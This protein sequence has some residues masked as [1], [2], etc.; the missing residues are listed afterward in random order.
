LGSLLCI[1]QGHGHNPWSTKVIREAGKEYSTLKKCSKS[2][3][4]DKI[5]GARKELYN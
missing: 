1:G 3:L 5:V 2:G 4:E